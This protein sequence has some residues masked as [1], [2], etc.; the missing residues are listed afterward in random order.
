MHT[1]LEPDQCVV[2]VDISPYNNIY[3]WLCSHMLLY[4][5]FIHSYY[6]WYIA[7]ALDEDGGGVIAEGKYFLISFMR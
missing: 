3:S 5:N 6:M 2:D 7:L 1:L 4:A